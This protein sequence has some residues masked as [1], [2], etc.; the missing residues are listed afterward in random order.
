[1][2]VMVL[3]SHRCGGRAMQSIAGFAGLCN[4]GRRSFGETASPAMTGNCGRTDPASTPDDIC[5][6][7]SNR[8]SGA[9]IVAGLYRVVM[10]VFDLGQQ[11][12]GIDMPQVDLPTD[13]PDGQISWYQSS[14]AMK[15]RLMK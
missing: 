6:I 7:G 13:L 4:V 12:P 1:M 10:G 15:R 8:A 2:L 5:R 3:A 9:N 11:R 14:D